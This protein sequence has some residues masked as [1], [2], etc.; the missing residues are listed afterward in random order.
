ME[1]TLC[2]LDTVPHFPHFFLLDDA[3]ENAV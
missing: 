3:A 1:H 2:V